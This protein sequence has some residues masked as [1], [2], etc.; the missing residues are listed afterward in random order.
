MAELARRTAQAV[1]N[2]DPLRLAIVVHREATRLPTLIRR[3]GEGPAAAVLAEVELD[4]NLRPRPPSLDLAR[5][6]QTTLPGVAAL[7]EARADLA[8]A[9]EDRA[10]ERRIASLLVATNALR[11]NKTKVALTDLAFVLARE[12]E[13]HGW[14]MIAAAAGIDQAQLTSHFPPEPADFIDAIGAWH[15][16]LDAAPLML[17]RADEALW[18]AGNVISANSKEEDIEF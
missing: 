2:T 8:A 6:L 12:A 15:A 9:L 4:H 17:R 11:T 13:V 5:R 16:R 10:D 14:P 7:M 18:A 3:I 1:D